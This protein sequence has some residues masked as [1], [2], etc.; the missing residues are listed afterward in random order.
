MS[1][2]K[3]DVRHVATLARLKPSDADVELYTEQLKRILGHAAKIAELDTDGVEPTTFTVPLRDASRL[4]EVKPSLGV[5]SALVNAPASE[6]GC[7]KVP[8]VIE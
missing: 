5:E 8:R 2:T 1:I 7:F 3:D 4:D 6:R